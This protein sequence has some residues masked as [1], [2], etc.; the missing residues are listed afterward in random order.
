M[1]DQN[2]EQQ[3]FW[4]DAAGPTW[5]AQMDAMDAALAPLLEGVLDRAALAPGE[6]VLDIGCGAGT[7]TISAAEQI[8]DAGHILGVDISATLMAVAAERAQGR[9]NIEFQVS[10][11]QTHEFDKAGFD[12]LISRLGVMFFDDPV[13]AF[14]NIA[15][16]LRPEG[17][18]IFASW[19]AIPDNPY[20]TLPAQVAKSM[21]GAVP[22][23]DPDAPGPFAF[24]APERVEAIL[25]ASGFEQIRVEEVPF[26][27]TANGSAEDVAALMCEI[28]PAQ[29]AL[30]HYEADGETRSRLIAVLADALKAFETGDGIRIPALI[31]FTS[32]RKPA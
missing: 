11:A 32:A 21:L 22:K 25:Q 20:F 7:S 29:R 1:S 5:V 16:A 19:G 27:L 4:T 8:G 30:Q 12:C 6:H 3:E 14:V 23:S 26:V 10:D 18:M 9:S 17:R 15:K 13:A 31:N 24:R 2:A 28:G